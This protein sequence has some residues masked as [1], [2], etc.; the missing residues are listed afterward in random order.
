MA[1]KFSPG[2]TVT[3]ND[4]SQATKIWTEDGLVFDVDVP[5][6]TRGTVANVLT[7]GN[8][9]TVRFP[10]DHLGRTWNAAA[11]FIEAHLSS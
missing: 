4:G 6:G 3:I 2:D 8:I 7:G 11:L 10:I 5:D 9:Y 1:N